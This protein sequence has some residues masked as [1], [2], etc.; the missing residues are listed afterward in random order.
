MIL[1]EDSAFPAT[2]VLETTYDGDLEEHLDDLIAHG[3]EALDA[4]YSL[5]EG[6]PPSGS[7]K[8]SAIRQISEDAFG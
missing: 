5:C 7:K 1:P 4:V 3:S 8:P 6:Y 2:L